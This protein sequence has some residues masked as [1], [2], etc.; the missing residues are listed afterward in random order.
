[1]I[2]IRLL[3]NALILSKHQNF[4]RAAKELHVSQPTLTRNIQQLEKEIGERLFDRASRAVLP[5]QAGKIMLKHARIIIASS[6]AMLEEIEQHHGLLQGSVSVGAGPYA[7][8]ELLAPLKCH[9][10][11]EGKCSPQ[12]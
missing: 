12:N 11:V 4:A 2:E 9:D 8:A 7:G 5:T 10:G 3:R 6:G 1:M